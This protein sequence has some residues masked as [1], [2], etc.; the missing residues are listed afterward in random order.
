MSARGR[1]LVLALTGLLVGCGAEAPAA[2]SRR[3]SST[4]RPAVARIE[5]GPLVVFLGDSLA[6][7]LHVD[8]DEAFPA[9]LQRRLAERG[10][11]FRLVN[12]GVSGDTTAGGLSRLDWLLAQDPDWVVVELGANDGLRGVALEAIE[13][14]LREIVERVEAHGA[15]ALLAGMRM[16]PNYGDAY[17][18]G[19]RAM[20]GRLAEE[21][22][23]E[24]VPFLLEGVGGVPE[25][26][27]PDGLHPTVEGHELIAEHLEPTFLRLVPEAP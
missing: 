17:A 11:P 18:K 14:N 25:M 13:A 15:R 2:G 7:G 1:W 3:S 10:R 24:Y 23:C 21:L 22:G 20:Y 8:A 19:F 4:P 6:A 16:P 26:N 12:A 27:L 9:V 5:E